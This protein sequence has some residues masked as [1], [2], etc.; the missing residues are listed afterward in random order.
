MKKNVLLSVVLTGVLGTSLFAYNG[1]NMQGMN[2]NGCFYNNTGKNM[3]NNY[4]KK[5]G[6][7]GFS[8]LLWQLNLTV[9]QRK[10]IQAIRQDMMK[11]RV[12]PSSA[13]TKNSFDKDKY[14]EIMKQKRDNMIKSKADMVGKIYAILS[15]EQKEQLKVLM[16]LR[17]ERMSSMMQGRMGF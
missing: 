8:S 5:M 16:D 15:K 10:D 11:N 9:E 13:F 3:M 7:Q 2:K 17:A 14:Y 1:N 12:R 6:R 4:S